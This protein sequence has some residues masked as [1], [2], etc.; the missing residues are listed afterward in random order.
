MLVLPNVA[1]PDHLK[2]H[3]LEL[4]KRYDPKRNTGRIQGDVVL[5][6][7]PPGGTK[8]SW[9]SVGATFS[10]IQGKGATQTA[11]AIAYAVDVRPGESMRF[12]EVYKAKVPTWAGHWRYNHDTDVKLDKPAEA[13]YVK[14]TGKPA[15]NAIRACLHVTPPTKHDPAVRITHGYKLDGKMTEKAVEL[16]KPGEY[17]IDCK[18]EKVENVFIR[19]EKR[20]M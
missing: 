12:K 19:I 15:V 18:G 14:F 13:V 11:N 5:K 2:N 10:T 4:P 1:D 20:S 8:I 6:L 17:S 16:S 3:V 9:F 7:I